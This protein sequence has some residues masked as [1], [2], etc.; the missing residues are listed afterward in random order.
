M[1]V[2]DLYLA[3]ISVY[4][5]VFDGAGNSSSQLKG[6][7][8]QSF[9]IAT[10]VTAAFVGFDNSTIQFIW[11]DLAPDTENASVIYQLHTD[12]SDVVG[13]LQSIQTIGFAQRMWQ[14][15]FHDLAHGLS[16]QQITDVGILVAL[17]VVLLAIIIVTFFFVRFR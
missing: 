8:I 4:A 7:L 16:S 13:S 15:E 17:V 9:T 12:A 14:F 1:T 6:V 10:I 2:C 3:L 11:R 5:P